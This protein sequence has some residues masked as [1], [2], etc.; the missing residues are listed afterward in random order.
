MIKIIINLY[1]YFLPGLLL[2]ST[3][4][5][6]LDVN[7]WYEINNKKEVTL[8]VSLFMSSECPHCHKA[9]EFF[10]VL[11]KE[12]WIKINR[13]VINQSDE[14][15]KNFYVYLQHFLS[16]DFAVPTVFFCDSRWVGFISEEVSGKKLL[17]SLN[18]CRAQIA[19]EGSLS[20]ATIQVLREKS[21][22]KELQ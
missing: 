8:N 7:N 18:Y 9:S 14:A 1:K 20:Q 15:L 6:A 22:L 5:F 21:E 19:K 13:Y 12:P 16:D 2:I 4:T 11:E 3:N 17:E 10:S